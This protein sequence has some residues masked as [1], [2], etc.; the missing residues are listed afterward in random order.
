VPSGRAIVLVDKSGDVCRFSVEKPYEDGE[1]LLG[2]LSVLLDIL[3]SPDERYIIT[4]DCGEKVRLS[5]YSNSYSVQ[6]Y[7][8]ATKKL[9]QDCLSFQLMRLF[10]CVSSGGGTVRFWV[11]AAGVEL[12]VVDCNGSVPTNDI[13][14][15]SKTDNGGCKC[16]SDRYHHFISMHL[17]IKIPGMPCAPS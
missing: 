10:L 11:Y 17:C 14:E 16:Q 7:C 3:V 15:D 9:L 13:V 1:L 2:H 8:L 5:R 4:C 6:S 12:C